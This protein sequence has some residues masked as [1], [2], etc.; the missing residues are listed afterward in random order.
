MH[1]RYEMHKKFDRQ[2]WKNRLF[3]R[4]THALEIHIKMSLIEMALDKLNCIRMAQ[5]RD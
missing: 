3:L 1:A 2:T 4:H 5:N